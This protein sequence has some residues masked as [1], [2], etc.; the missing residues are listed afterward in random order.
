ME[1]S[2][3]PAPPVPLRAILVGVAETKEI[4]PADAGLTVIVPVLVKAVPAMESVA[5]IVSR[6]PQLESL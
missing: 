5:V 2:L 6:V 4:D 1:V 3:L